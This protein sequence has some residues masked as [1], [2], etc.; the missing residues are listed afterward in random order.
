MSPDGKHDRIVDACGPHGAGCVPRQPAWSHDGRRYAISVGDD[1]DLSSPD[2]VSSPS[3]GAN[4]LIAYT[5]RLRG[6]DRI[7]AVRPDRTRRRALARGSDPDWSRSGR[8]LAF[9]RRGDIYVASASGR[10]QRLVT[11]GGFE[12]AWSPSGRRIAFRTRGGAIATVRS[13]GRHRRVVVPASPAE[14]T[15]NESPAWRPLP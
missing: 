15:A 7:E 6:G 14:F 1:S 11:G 5:A 13:D 2:P 3:W 8:R 10:H 4:G 9:E 12:P